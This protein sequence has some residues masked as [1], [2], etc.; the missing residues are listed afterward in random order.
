MPAVRLTFD[1]WCVS[2]RLATYRQKQKRNRRPALSHGGTRDQPATAS[3][4]AVKMQTALARKTVIS[5]IPHVSSPGICGLTC[6][7]RVAGSLRRG[8][9]ILLATCYQDERSCH[10]GDCR[11]EED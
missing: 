6:G 4:A 8:G 2:G 10:A 9:P 5:N 3:A 11:N 1:S 7:M